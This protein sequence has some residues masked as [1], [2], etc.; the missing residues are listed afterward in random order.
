MT[1]YI[2]RDE[3]AGWRS[4]G[5]R[6]LAT[7]CISPLLL[8]AV[9]YCISKGG[10]RLN[11]AIMLSSILCLIHFGFLVKCGSCLGK[12]YCPTNSQDTST[13]CVS[14]PLNIEGIDMIEMCNT[15]AQNAQKDTTY[16]YIFGGCI[17]SCTTES[18]CKY[19]D[20][21]LPGYFCNIVNHDHD[22][23]IISTCPQYKADCIKLLLNVSYPNLCEYDCF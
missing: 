4:Q 10:I 22:I 16:E 7:M 2:F 12:Y 13:L 11:G 1:Y 9:P 18:V 15:I 3:E 20:T 19:D 8:G 21:T 14:C 6:F 23:G 5:F 17:T